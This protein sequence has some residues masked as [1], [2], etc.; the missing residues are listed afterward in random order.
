[1]GRRNFARD[2]TY[3]FVDK[4]VFAEVCQHIEDWRVTAAEFL[5]YPI[6]VAAFPAA[7]PP[8]FSKSL[9]KKKR[10]LSSH[11][12]ET[13]WKIRAYDDPAMLSADR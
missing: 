2:P 5:R 13:D 10:S 3:A 7:G 1:M 8:D 6:T 4:E 9:S 12:R 11:H